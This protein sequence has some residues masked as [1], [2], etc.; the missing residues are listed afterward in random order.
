VKT[1]RLLL[2]GIAIASA[3]AAPAS[4]GPTKTIRLAWSERATV[5]SRTI[6][7]FNVRSLTISGRSWTVNASFR[8]TSRTTLRIRKR[9]A[10]L[11][12]PSSV[13][14]SGMK[15]LP[16]KTFRPALPAT[17]PPGKAWSGR[18]SGVGAGALRRTNVRVQFS[19]FAGR[20]LPG[21]PGFG[22]ITDHVARLG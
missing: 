18:L 10:V 1:A 19:Y 17:L 16:A 9:F 3:L 14:V 13:S 8:N 20:A 15:M 4:A 11:Y 22:W 7:T 5:G 21:R 12:G 2:L 6:M